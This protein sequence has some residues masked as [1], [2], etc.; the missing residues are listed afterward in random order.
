MFCI[1][2]GFNIS[3]GFCLVFWVFFLG[4]LIRKLKV[5]CCLLLGSLVR[6][7]MRLEVGWGLM[8]IVYILIKGLFR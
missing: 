6:V 3:F 5:S 4:F 2:F 1:M 8:G 7:N